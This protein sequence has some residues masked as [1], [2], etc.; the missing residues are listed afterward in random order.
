MRAAGDG[1]GLAAR[2]GQG[3]PGRRTADAVEAGRRPGGGRRRPLRFLL[4]DPP[5][6]TAAKARAADRG[7]IIG[8]GVWTRM[9]WGGWA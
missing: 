4:L 7:C 6:R 3:E 1:E 8:P 5:P 9:R 2:F